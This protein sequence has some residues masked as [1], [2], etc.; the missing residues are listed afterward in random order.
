MAQSY[1]V[2]YPTMTLTRSQIMD[3][4]LPTLKLIPAAFNRSAAEQKFDSVWQSYM[5]TGRGISC[6]SV[7]GGLAAT[8]TWQSVSFQFLLPYGSLWV[9]LWNDTTPDNTT[10]VLEENSVLFATQNEQ[11]KAF[12]EFL[13]LLFAIAEG[14][15]AEFFVL[16][17]EPELRT[18]SAQDVIEMLNPV[19]LKEKEDRVFL[20]A[21]RHDLVP[22]A[23]IGVLPDEYVASTR[24]G[25]LF[26]RVKSFGGSIDAGVGS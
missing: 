7:E 18:I 24:N 6:P 19:R 2:L 22:A 9:S 4:V 12:G 8:E 20:L 23:V 16:R 17:S 3:I 14:T 5:S 11:P 10:L 25:Y 15:T 13:E 1:F 26:L 21:V